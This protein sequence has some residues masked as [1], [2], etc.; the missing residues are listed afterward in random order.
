M[1]HVR[2]QL[3]A[4]TAALALT[5]TSGA[6]ASPAFADPRET[7]KNATATGYGGAVST[8]DP[9]AS[10]AA[11]EVLKRG[12]NAADAAVAAAAT[13]GVTEPYSAGIGGGGYFVFYD[14]KTKQVGTIDGRETAPAGMKNDAFI[15]P[16]TKKPYNFTPELVTS[17]VSVGVPGTPATWERALERWG[18]MGL[19]DALKPAIKVANRGFVVDETFRQQTLDNK[20]RFDAFTSTRDLFLPGG[21]A[22][23]VGS[24]FKNHDLAATYRTLAKEGTDAFYG[25]PLA[26]EIAQTVQAPPKTAETKLPIPVGSM[27]A[28]D[29]AN[30]KVVDQDATKVEYRGLDVYGMAPSSS[31]GT[32]VGEALNILE[33][34]DLKGMKPAD[35]LHHYFE[36]SSLAF[37]D[38]GAYVGDP[39]FVKVPTKT[40]L[41]DVFAKERSCEIDPTAAAD[42]P[43]APGNI[44]TYDGACPAAVA[45]LANETDT[46]NISTTNMTV[47]DKWGNVVEYTLTIEQTGGSGIVVPGRGFLL[48]N[49]LTDFSTVYD[50]KDPNRIE[51]NK[52]PRS[53]MSPTI[54]LKDQKPFLALGSPGGSTIITTVLQTILNRVDLGMTVSEA[55]A[56]PRAAPRNGATV[57]SEPAFIDAYGPAL[58]SL[59][60]DLVPAGDAFTSAAEIGA[61]TAIEFGR[62]GQMTA[63]AEPTRRGGGSALVVKPVKP[64]R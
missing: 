13:L 52:R 61:A 11:I 46:E 15:D 45:P 24:V 53:S 5:A 64:G 7:D 29:L 20:L 26:E 35:A 60:H 1:T 17:G 57:S 36:A 34:Y 58:T 31:G 6:M 27:T 23:A 10:A 47:A 44:E 54:I 33:N 50:A 14:A 51:P 3:A 16:A 4:V 12:G 21:D 41:D 32:T 9:E 30:Y 25:G 37:A 18:T 59:G 2:R 63:A 38:R 19:G 55:L 28:P 42:K 39:A 8:V 43:V 22:P 40:L 49:E 56:A 62:D 48:N